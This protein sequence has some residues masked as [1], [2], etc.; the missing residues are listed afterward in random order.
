MIY[1]FYYSSLPADSRY[2][3]FPS[4]NLQIAN[5]RQKDTGVYRCGAKN[6]LTGEIKESTRRTSLKVYAPFGTKL[7]E[8]VHTPADT[9][10]VRVGA[11]LTLECVANGAP[12]PLVSW[13]KFGGILPEKRATQVYGNLILTDLQLEDKGTYVCRAENG[14]GQATFKTAMIDVFESPVSMSQVT[15]FPKTN[16]NALRKNRMIN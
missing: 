15:R 6:P 3:V 4:G 5:V 10:R 1:Y 13:E 11:N 12:V 14:P 7:P 8:I 2:K 16:C 9:N